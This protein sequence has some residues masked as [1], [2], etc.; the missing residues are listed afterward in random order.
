[1]IAT[2]PSDVVAV[3]L[4]TAGHGKRPSQNP[5]VDDYV[6]TCGAMPAEPAHAIALRDTTPEIRGRTRG[7]NALTYPAIQIRVRA[8]DYAEG[9]EKCVAIGNTLDAVLRETVQ[10]GS[11]SVLVHN[12]RLASGPFHLGPTDDGNREEFTI[13]YLITAKDIA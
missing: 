6:I 10:V 5:D 9:W 8:L 3:L 13:N 11:A 2:P 4:E 12:C 1:M 7:F